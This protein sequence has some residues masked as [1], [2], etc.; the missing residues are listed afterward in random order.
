MPLTSPNHTHLPPPNRPHPPEEKV[1]L[2]WPPLTLPTFPSKPILPTHSIGTYGAPG[3][4]LGD[5]WGTFQSSH[6]QRESGD[7]RESLITKYLRGNSSEFFLRLGKSVSF[8]FNL[9]FA[10]G[11][12]NLLQSYIPKQFP[13]G[14]DYIWL[15]SLNF[16]NIWF[17]LPSRWVGRT[18][19]KIQNQN[20][21]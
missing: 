12:A 18:Q 21:Q 6:L 8:R 11:L 14:K 1:I 4:D 16:G 15:F 19:L 3:I 13:T 10:T 17:Q 20:K 7:S 2:L 9:K 5:H